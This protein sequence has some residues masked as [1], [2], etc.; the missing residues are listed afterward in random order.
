MAAS[1]E[2]AANL[3]LMYHPQ[4]FLI[5]SNRKHLFTAPSMWNAVTAMVVSLLNPNKR[6]VASPRPGYS[7]TKQIQSACE[8]ESTRSSSPLRVSGP[9][10]IAR[11]ILTSATPPKPLRSMAHPATSSEVAAY[12]SSNDK[13]SQIETGPQQTSSTTNGKQIT[14]QWKSPPKRQSFRR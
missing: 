9:G 8:H 13:R 7:N 5:L 10:F 1:L 3:P 2:V 14:E 11:S 6:S 12:V 4:L